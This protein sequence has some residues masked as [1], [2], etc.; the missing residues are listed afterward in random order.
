MLD[1]APH[2]PAARQ[3]LT[4]YLAGVG[5]ATGAVVQAA[6]PRERSSGLCRTALGIDD[7]AA[8]R[9][10]GAIALERRAETPATPLLVAD[11]LARAGCRLPE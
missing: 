3:T 10:L 2:N 11:M 4:A 8:R 6:R 7:G 1:D 9:V 5:E